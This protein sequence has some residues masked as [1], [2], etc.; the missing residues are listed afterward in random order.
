MIERLA[1][2]HENARVLAAGLSRV[3]GLTCDA[4]GV[5]TNIVMVH[6]PGLAAAELV[7]ACRSRG[8]LALASGPERVRLVTH[9]GIERHD[10][11]EALQIAQDAITSLQAAVR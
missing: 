7:G 1:E 5:E 3:P 6:T 8:L 11:E 2:D 9:Y 4:A 10:V